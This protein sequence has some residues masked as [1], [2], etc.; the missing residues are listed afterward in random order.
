MD[1]DARAPLRDA[2]AAADPPLATPALVIDLDTVDRNIAALQRLCGTRTRWRPHVKTVKQGALIGRLLAA[3]VRTFKCASAAELALVLATADAHGVAVDVLWAY[4]LGRV[5]ITE[6][7]RVVT[8]WPGH[9]LGVLADDA[10]HLMWLAQRAPSPVL[11]WLDVD[12]G[13][14][15]TGSPPEHW[16]AHASVVAARSDRL[17]GIHGYEGHIA[18]GDRAGARQAHDALVELARRLPAAP[19]LHTSGSVTLLDAVAHDDLHDRRWIHEIGAGTLVLGD[20]A[21]A[22]V[23]RRIGAAPAAF[24][25][26]RPTPDR[27]T[28]DAGSKAITPDR[29]PPSC[30]VL[31]HAELR[32]MTA[33]EEHLPCAIDPERSTTLRRDDL[34]LLVPDHVC[35]TVNLYREAVLARTDR[36]VGVTAIEASGRAT[37]GDL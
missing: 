3:G 22:T 21:C 35:T 18:A 24:V 28:L 29:P 32:A 26:A 23:G 14:H 34:V 36:L 16:N 2:V 30:I 15:R 13:M 12:L 37:L 19:V 11:L 5:G 9:T 17:G 33:S 25:A 31:G 6:L 8:H 1:L 10:D 4:P 20:V 7:E 27:I